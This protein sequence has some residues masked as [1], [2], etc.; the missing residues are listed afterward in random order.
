MMCLH[1]CSE[2]TVLRVFTLGVVVGG[3]PHALQQ[4]RKL[5]AIY[6]CQCSGF[7]QADCSLRK[8]A[9]G[10]QRLDASLLA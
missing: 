10:K 3:Q 7:G 9:H 2:G 4:Q 8:Q 5:V 1:G 6:A